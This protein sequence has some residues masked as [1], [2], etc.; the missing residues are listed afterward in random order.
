LEKE[1]F[2]DHET[3]GR[4][5]RYFPLVK[6]EAYR[7]SSFRNLIDNY[8]GGSSKQLLSYFVKEENIDEA[9]IE[10]L[11]REIKE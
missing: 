2:I 10:A 7:Q 9:E 11:L 8:F 1:G 4:N 5:H 6:K 3:F